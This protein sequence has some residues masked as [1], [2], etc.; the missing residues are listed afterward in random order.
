[1]ISLENTKCDIK[2][3]KQGQR[4]WFIISIFYFGLITTLS[5]IPG[6]AIA[7]LGFNIWDKAAHFTVYAVLGLFLGLGFSH[8]LGHKKGRILLFTSLVAL[9]LGALD[10][11]HQLFVQGRCASVDDWFADGLGA[12]FGGIWALTPYPL[13][14]FNHLRI[15]K[16]MKRKKAS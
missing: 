9:T 7:S 2:D 13:A 4:Q 1:M 12:A 15:S 11:T 16:P 10:E 3:R 6:N 5:H 14:V 8:R